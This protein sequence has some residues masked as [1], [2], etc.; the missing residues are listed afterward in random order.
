MK[1]LHPVRNRLPMGLREPHRQ[2][3]IAARMQVF[4][5]EEYGGRRRA[6]LPRGRPRPLFVLPRGK[7]RKSGLCFRIMLAWPDGEIRLGGRVGANK[8]AGKS[9]FGPAC[10]RGR[11]ER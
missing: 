10:W 2:A 9:G 4:P 11:T 6:W 8:C 1:I 7:I 3:K 5:C